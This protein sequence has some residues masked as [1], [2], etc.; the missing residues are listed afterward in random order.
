MYIHQNIKY[1]R[2]IKNLTQSD[3]GD[4]LGIVGNQIARYERG[5]SDP[6]VTKIIQ[7]ADLF[8]VSLQDLVLTDLSKEEPKFPRPDVAYGSM[9]E[10]TKEDAFHE[11]NEELRKRI[12]IFEAFAASVA[13]EEARKWGLIE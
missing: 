5:D 7:L 4:T 1:L 6:P 12:K 2:K 3:L 13:P 9:D 8:E 11:L 10:E